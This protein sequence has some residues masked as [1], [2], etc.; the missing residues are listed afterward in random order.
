MHV[1]LDGRVPWGEV[2]PEWQDGSA[3]IVV[4]RR[5]GSD[6]CYDAFHSQELHD[7]LAPA[8]ERTI[9]VEYN[10]FSDFG[11]V[12]SYNVRSVDGLLLANGQHVVRDIEVFGGQ[13]LGD[14]TASTS[15]NT[16]F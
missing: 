12:R 3:P 6:Y 16:C 1:A 8:R 9:T 15:T 5:M 14:K 7:R 13:I 10:V 11:R 4:Y 2:G